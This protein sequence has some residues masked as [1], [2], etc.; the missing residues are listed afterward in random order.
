[1]SIGNRIQID[2]EIEMACGAEGVKNAGTQASSDR[3]TAWCSRICGS[4]TASCGGSEKGMR[5]VVRAP[6]RR[7]QK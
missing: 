7:R 3:H 4:E 6:S 5:I 1:V 2:H